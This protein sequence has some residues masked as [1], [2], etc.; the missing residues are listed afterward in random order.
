M[1]I[2]ELRVWADELGYDIM[3][4]DDGSQSGNVTYNFRKH[5]NADIDEYVHDLQSLENFLEELQ[6]KKDRAR[7]EFNKLPKYD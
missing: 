4:C 2:S 5:G 1:D 3:D 6:N 7:E